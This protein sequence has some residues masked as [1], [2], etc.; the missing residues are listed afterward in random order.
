MYVGLGQWQ[1]A[2][3]KVTI[4]GVELEKSIESLNLVIVQSGFSGW[5]SCSRLSRLISCLCQRS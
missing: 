3:S 4:E 2:D 5:S 1:Q